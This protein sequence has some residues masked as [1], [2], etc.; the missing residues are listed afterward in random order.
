VHSSVAKI[1]LKNRIRLCRKDGIKP[2]VAGRIALSN[3]LGRVPEV[4]GRNRRLRGT[5][6][7]NNRAQLLYD[8]TRD[9]RRN[10]DGRNSFREWLLEPQKKRH[11]VERR[12]FRAHNERFIKMWIQEALAM[13]L[14]L[15]T[16]FFSKINIRRNLIWQ[17]KSLIETYLKTYRNIVMYKHE[18]E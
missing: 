12:L 11:K 17:N 10:I 16:M 15:C 7:W 8:T 18:Q 13:Q 1:I 3:V 2:P 4:S 14:S 6:G 9:R 5:R